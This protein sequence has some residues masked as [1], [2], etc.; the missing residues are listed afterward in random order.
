MGCF[1]SVWLN[2]WRVARFPETLE[3]FWTVWRFYGQFEPFPDSLGNIPD[4][5]ENIC[6]VK[7][8]LYRQKLFFGQSVRFWESLIYFQTNFRQF[9]SWTLWF[10]LIKLIFNSVQWKECLPVV[11]RTDDLLS[12]S[13][14]RCLSAKAGGIKRLVLTSLTLLRW[15]IDR[16]LKAIDYL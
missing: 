10:V 16:G 1:Y 4:S 11:S 9:D 3:D 14:N 7:L 2:L 8:T 12:A 13:F 5:L 15:W 6:K